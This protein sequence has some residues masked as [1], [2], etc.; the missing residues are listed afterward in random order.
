MNLHITVPRISFKRIKETTAFDIEGPIILIPYREFTKINTSSKSYKIP[1]TL[2]V[3]TKLIQIK[4]Q[5]QRR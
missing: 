4:I 3:T 2:K 1:L 5:K